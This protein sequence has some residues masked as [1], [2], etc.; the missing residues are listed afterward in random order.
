ML[1]GWLPPLLVAAFTG[2]A[3]L[4]LGRHVSRGG[5]RP[6]A[7]TAAAG[8]AV[9]A[10]ALLLELAMGRPSVYRGGPIRVWSGAVASD[11]NSQQLADP[12]SLTHVIHGAAFYALVRLAGPPAPAVRALLAL[13]LESAWEVLENTDMVID[14]YRA[15]TISLGYRGDSALNS[16]GDIV[17]CL[18]GFVLAWRLPARATLFGVAA[19]EVGLLVWI[20]DNLTLNIVMLLHPIDAIRV[21]QAGG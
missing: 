15:A 9:V 18:L 21:W 13:G 10:L 8:L 17:A 11:E 2:L 5:R 4:L 16:L 14:R 20:R 1:D 19:I 6:G 3:V 12:Y 7:A